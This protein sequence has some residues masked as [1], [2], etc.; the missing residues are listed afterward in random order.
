MKL[1]KLRTNILLFLTII[2]FTFFSAW[3]FSKEPDS[4]VF[5]V[6]ASKEFNKNFTRQEFIDFAKA[7]NTYP[8][9]FTMKKGF[10]SPYFLQD[11]HVRI[12]SNGHIKLNQNDVG[13][14]A[15]F[16]DLRLVLAA[17]FWHRTKNKDFKEGTNEI[18]KR[19]FVAASSSIEY[20]KVIKV[21]DALK[22]TGAEPIVL[23]IDDLPN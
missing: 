12:N 3:Y 22:E 19:V 14:L 5:R 7:G 17:Q 2:T 20:E 15:D 4:Q 21:I 23:Q 13:T 1:F 16:N 6:K 18:Y 11:L 10:V 8:S 9:M